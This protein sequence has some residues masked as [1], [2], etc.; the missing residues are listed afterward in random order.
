MS[1]QYHSRW[2]DARLAIP[3]DRY[4][5]PTPPA[6]RAPFDHSYQH[7]PARRSKRYQQAFRRGMILGASF[8]LMLG[9]LAWCGYTL[10][11]SGLRPW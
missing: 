4:A 6:R 5:P 2:P 3:P 1:R 11:S 10:Y 8:T 7:G 9:A